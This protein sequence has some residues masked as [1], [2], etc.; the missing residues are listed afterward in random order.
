MRSIDLANK[1]SK[2]PK[3][4]FENLKPNGNQG[5]K[6]DFCNQEKHPFHMCLLI[7]LLPKKI[8]IEC[9]DKGVL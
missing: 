4:L 7:S 5:V 2:T 8:C 1:N 3:R 9:R 6:C